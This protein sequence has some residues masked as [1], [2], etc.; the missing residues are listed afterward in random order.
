MKKP[1]GHPKMFDAKDGVDSSAEEYEINRLKVENQFIRNL[2]HKL[3]VM[4][5]K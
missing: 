5:E 4:K 2:Y 1:V 3:C